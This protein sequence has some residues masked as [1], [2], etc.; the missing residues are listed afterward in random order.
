MTAILYTPGHLTADSRRSQ[1]GDIVTDDATK[2]RRFGDVNHPLDESKLLHFKGELVRVA[3]GAGNSDGI[4]LFLKNLG[5]YGTDVINFYDDAAHAFGKHLRQ[6]EFTVLLV[7]DK[8]LHQLDIGPLH[9]RPPHPAGKAVEHHQWPLDTPYAIGSGGKLALM[10]YQFFR[11]PPTLAVAAAGLFDPWTGGEIVELE[12]RHEGKHTLWMETS[13][14][15]RD[16][17]E[18]MDA[19]TDH[20]SEW[21]VGTHPF[22]CLGRPKRKARTVHVPVHR[23][24][25][26][27]KPE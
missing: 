19:L 21:N 6:S 13:E 16:R 22:E 2:L 26:P 25:R 10:L 24:A 5:R 23:V 17:A 9:P 18:I 20:F 14:R 15:Y 12:L 1:R 27:P 7:G 11:V 4:E 3:G 8:Y